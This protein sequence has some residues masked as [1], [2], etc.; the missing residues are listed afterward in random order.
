MVNGCQPRSPLIKAPGWRSAVVLDHHDG[1]LRDGH[2]RKLRDGKDEALPAEQCGGI[3]GR[4]AAW[5]SAA[6]RLVGAGVGLG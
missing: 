3:T 2:L 1:P 5:C 6:G 4:A